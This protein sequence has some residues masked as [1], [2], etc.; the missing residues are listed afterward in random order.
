M[1]SSAIGPLAFPVNRL[2]WPQP[3]EAGEKRAADSLDA[4]PPRSTPPIMVPADPDRGSK[5]DIRI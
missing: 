3:I 1:I 2:S 5:L 4:V